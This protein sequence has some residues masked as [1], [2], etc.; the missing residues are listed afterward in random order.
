MREKIIAHGLTCGKWI[1]IAEAAASCDGRRQMYC[2]C[3]ACGTVAIIRLDRLRNGTATPCRCE[4]EIP[5]RLPIGGGYACKYR[6]IGV[7][8]CETRKNRRGYCCYH[9]EAKEECSSACQNTPDKCGSFMLGGKKNGTI[10]G[11]DQA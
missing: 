5:Y 1:A 6:V 9:C 2:R 10:N 7:K 4:K 3:T 8:E 11:S